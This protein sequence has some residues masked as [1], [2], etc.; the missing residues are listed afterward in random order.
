MTKCLQSFLAIILVIK[1]ARNK[2][3]TFAFPEV[4]F[5]CLLERTLFEVSSCFVRHFYMF[6]LTPL[7][8]VA[9]LVEVPLGASKIPR[10]SWS[11]TITPIYAFS[12][13]FLQTIIKSLISKKN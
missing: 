12:A 13:I 3:S 1:I 10:L 2:N 9:P 4:T 11:M 7:H 8:A 5:L 6:V